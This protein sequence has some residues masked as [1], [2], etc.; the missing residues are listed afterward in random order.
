MTPYVTY[1]NRMRRNL[2]H[3]AQ[4]RS[5]CPRDGRIFCCRSRSND[6]RQLR[7]RILVRHITS[8]LCYQNNYKSTALYTILVGIE[9]YA[10]R[11]EKGDYQLPTG[12][13]RTVCKTERKKILA[14]AYWWT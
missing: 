2:A 7:R 12:G 11:E 9:F 5:H 3:N 10:R 1:L 4:W 13:K 8:R 14:V 6:V